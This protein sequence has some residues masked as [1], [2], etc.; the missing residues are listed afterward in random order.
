MNRRMIVLHE[1]AEYSAKYQPVLQ[2]GASPQAQGN[3]AV[4]SETKKAPFDVK[5]FST[6]EEFLAELG[7]SV[8]NKQPFAGAFFDFDLFPAN[9]AVEI[10]KKGKELDPHLLWF[11]SAKEQDKHWDLVHRALGQEFL[12]RWDFV[13]KPMT[14]A[15]LLQKAW[16]LSSS[17]DRRHREREYLQQIKNHEDQM[18]RTERLAA[19]GTL[20]RGLG[21]EFGNMLQTILT[22]ADLALAK[23][24]VPEM[25]VALKAIITASERASSVVKNLQSLVKMETTR[26]SINIEEPIKEALQLIEFEMKKDK[27]VFVPEYDGALPHLKVNRF[28]IN[29]AF[30]N[31]LVN[32]VHA[33]EKKGGELRIK[34]VNDA[35]GISIH[36]IDQGC[37]IPKENLEKIFEPLFTTKVGTGSGIGLS[38]TRRIVE[39]H[40]GKLSVTSE[41]GKGSS[42]VVWLPKK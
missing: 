2:P 7:A 24:T 6:A 30:L 25:E 18:V 13:P 8:A 5:Y 37:G 19:I 17:W 20:A 10:L 3:L 27:V 21:N 42:F 34:T 1:K 23:K 35:N 40:G 41:V 38:V 4:Q 14:P 31:I 28:E 22:K 39:N 29:Q 11:I 32:A 9:E 12:D 16:R 33:M 15:Q 26:E 36:F